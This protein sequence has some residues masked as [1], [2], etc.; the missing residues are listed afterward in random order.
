MLYY[1]KKPYLYNKI[2]FDF[3]IISKY[4]SYTKKFE[5]FFSKNK[6]MNRMKQ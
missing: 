2:P 3:I 4:N 1:I 5:L 6:Q